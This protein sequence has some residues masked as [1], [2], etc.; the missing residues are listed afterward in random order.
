MLVVGL[1]VSLSIHF[2]HKSLC[3]ANDKLFQFQTFIGTG[4]SYT[5]RMDVPHK[6]YD[7][8]MISWWH[9]T[10]I[11]KTWSLTK[12]IHIVLVDSNNDYDIS[13]FERINPEVMQAALHIK[14]QIIED[15]MCIDSLEHIILK[16]NACKRIW[17]AVHNRGTEALKCPSRLL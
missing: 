8:K 15:R 16:S 1:F 14:W 5:L 3:W 7:F 4:Y 12:Y 13:G 9:N 10:W 2:I 6:S 17:L 11:C